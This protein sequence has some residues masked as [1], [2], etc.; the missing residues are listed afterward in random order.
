MPSESQESVVDLDPT[1]MDQIDIQKFVNSFV[2]QI[3]AQ[4]T[5]IAMLEASNI[6]KDEKIKVLTI[7]NE[8]LQSMV[9]DLTHQLAT[10]VTEVNHNGRTTRAKKGR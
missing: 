2:R 1:Q 7:N 9:D 5:T 10:K 4:A 3:G 6:D 8:R